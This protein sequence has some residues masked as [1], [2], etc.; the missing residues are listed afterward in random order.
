MN[1]KEKIK[2]KRLKYEKLDVS[3]WINSIKG[4]EEKKNRSS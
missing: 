4:T 1:Y 3:W 2:D